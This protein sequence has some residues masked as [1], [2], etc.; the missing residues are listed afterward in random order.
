[1]AYLADRVRRLL[2]GTPF[3]QE[4]RSG[5]AAFSHAQNTDGCSSPGTAGIYLVAQPAGSGYSTALLA[6]TACAQASRRMQLLA[7][8]VPS[9][10]RRSYAQDARCLL[11]Q[12]I[13][14]PSKPHGLGPGQTEVLLQS[15]KGSGHQLVHQVQQRF[16]FCLMLGI[17]SGAEDYDFPH[18]VSLLAAIPNAPG[19]WAQASHQRL[20][21]GPGKPRGAFPPPRVLPIAR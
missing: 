19:P 7:R 18:G 6:R 1:V 12:C 3:S 2:P 14:P 10:A 4:G 15:R 5:R 13:K 9:L 16:A 21:L 17:A 8:L 11:L 20:R